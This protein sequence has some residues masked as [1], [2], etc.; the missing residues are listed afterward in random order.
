MP[1]EK[2]NL[3]CPTCGKP[4]DVNAPPIGF[5]CSERCKLIDL[6]KWL[7]EDYRISEPL[8]PDHFEAF[9]DLS[10]GHLDIPDQSS[11]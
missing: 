3:K 1:D 11:D 7:E 10:R 5:F 9:K 4:S 8:R 2:P 6:G